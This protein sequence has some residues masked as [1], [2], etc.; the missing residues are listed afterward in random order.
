MRTPVGYVSKTPVRIHCGK[1][2]TLL[3]GEFL[4]DNTKLRIQ[5][6]PLNCEEVS[7]QEFDYFGEASG[8][9]L[10]NKVMELHAEKNEIFNLPLGKASPVFDF[11][12]STPEPDRIR[13]INYVCYSSALTEQW[14]TQR[15]KYDLYLKGKKEL[16]IEKYREEAKQFWCQPDSDIGILQFTFRSLFY[17]L[18]GLFKR[19]ELEELLR[20]INYHFCHLNQVKLAEYI[21]EIKQSNRLHIVQEKIFKIVNDYI[22]V[23]PYLIPAIGVLYYTNAE[24]VDKNEM[25]MSTC[26][27]E[28]IKKFYQDTYESLVDCC[29]V[30][31]GLDNIENRGDCNTFTN[32]LN[33]DKFRKQSKGNRIT[34]LNDSEY[35]VGVFN[36]PISS[37]SLRNAIGHSD[38]EYDGTK[39]EIS[40]REKNGSDVILTASLLDVA[41]ECCKMMRSVCILSFMVYELYRYDMHDSNSSL[42]MHPMMYKW[43]K[44][45]SRCP[46]GSGKKYKQC[47]KPMID[48]LD[49]TVLDMDYPMR[50][51]CD[52]PSKEEIKKLFSLHQRDDFC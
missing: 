17:D 33:L 36:L 35:F 44:S 51:E 32:R 4:I 23:A 1:C 30:V 47:C 45:Q 2:D 7:P 25:G 20:K 3:T 43:V 19:N 49:E 5:Y 40:Y 34:F 11:M 46:C 27:F 28:D 31:V 6:V 10:C 15:I 18:G 9:L 13:F 21:A 48:F 37:N 26:S 39:Q 41:L 52:G 24:I 14:D 8:E 12:S 50:A 29:D 22:G 16:L 42:L 38:Y